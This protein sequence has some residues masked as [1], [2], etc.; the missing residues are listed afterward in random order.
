MK[1]HPHDPPA[2]TAP[3]QSASAQTAPGAAEAPEKGTGPT[4][5]WG[6]PHGSLTRAQRRQQI[7][8]KARW[9]FALRGY[10]NCTMEEIAEACF[11]SKPVIY[12][13]FASKAALYEAVV[14]EDLDMIGEAVRVPLPE[15]RE[16]RPVAQ[17]FVER[18]IGVV[19]E[20]PVSYRLIFEADR[21]QHS[22]LDQ[23]LEQLL[24]RAAQDIAQR[25]EARGRVDEHEGRFLGQLLIRTAV[26]TAQLVMAE[27]D[28]ARKRVFQQLAYTL[29]GGGL[30]AVEKHR[31]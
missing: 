16:I 24:T 6:V 11:V 17:A 10:H 5:A 1:A 7:V 9:N 21:P 3:A 27:E 26:E 22:D 29:A 28:P 15:V 31:A 19:L 4:P 2:Q 23:R 13:H 12:Q 25:L 18:F 8:T 20:H 14:S 30:E